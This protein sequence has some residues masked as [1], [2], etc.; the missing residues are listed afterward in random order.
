MRNL[1]RLPRNQPSLMLK[2]MSGRLPPRV[3]Q[4][5]WAAHA[6]VMCVIRSRILRPQARNLGK[7]AGSESTPTFFP[8]VV[9]GLGHRRPCSIRDIQRRRPLADIARAAT[10]LLSVLQARHGNKFR[11]APPC[12]GVAIP[13]GNERLAVTTRSLCWPVD[14][15]GSGRR[16][17]AAPRNYCYWR[18]D[19]LEAFAVVQL[20]WVRCPRRSCPRCAQPLGSS[21]VIRLLRPSGHRPT[22]GMIARRR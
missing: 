16:E 7:R 18:Y 8:S 5:Q 2:A 12:F 17:L 19:L 15:V 11:S 3:A 21:T 6:P 22:R 9:S 14:R 20:S 10:L 4:P 13:A 1:K